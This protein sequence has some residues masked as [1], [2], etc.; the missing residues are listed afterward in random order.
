[1]IILTRISEKDFCVD[2]TL[3]NF[4]TK[5]MEY[6]KIRE[7]LSGNNE[8]FFTIQIIDTSL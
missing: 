2:I 8:F 1:M 5:K 6:I 3:T 7:I 4:H